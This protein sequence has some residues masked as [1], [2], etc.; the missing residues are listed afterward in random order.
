MFCH[1]PR[2]WPAASRHVLFAADKTGKSFLS[3]F[4]IFVQS[5][6]AFQLP[7]LQT[8]AD[9]YHDPAM[10]CSSSIPPNNTETCFSSASLH[11]HTLICN[12]NASSTTTTPLT[13]T[14]TSSPCAAAFQ[15]APHK[16][17]GTAV[18]SPWLRHIISDF[19]LLPK[20]PRHRHASKHPLFLLPS[21]TVLLW[22]SYFSSD[23]FFSAYLWTFIT[24]TP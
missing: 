16:G 15:S 5:T 23:R 12:T 9:L 2:K 20:L 6:V 11:S 21:V 24:S 13:E 1:S 7:P 22:V 4:P 18:T 3:V 8:A 17:C 19:P 10:R 14:P